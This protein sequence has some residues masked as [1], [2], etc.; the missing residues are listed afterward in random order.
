MSTFNDPEVTDK[1]RAEFPDGKV[2][3]RHVPDA[4]RLVQVG[5][6]TWANEITERVDWLDELLNTKHDPRDTAEAV[7]ILLTEFD[8][9]IEKIAV[10]MG[11]TNQAVKRQAEVIRKRYA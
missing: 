2:P 6:N 1:F 5:F 9:P 8:V 11:V 10:A 7:R 4:L 3:I